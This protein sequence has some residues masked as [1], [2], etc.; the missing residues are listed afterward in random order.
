M[1]RERK[2][3]RSHTYAATIGNLTL[4]AEGRTKREA[5]KRLRTAFANA[6]RPTIINVAKEPTDLAYNDL[7]VMYQADPR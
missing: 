3:T 4:K 1:K 5:E 6:G 2:Y 7:L